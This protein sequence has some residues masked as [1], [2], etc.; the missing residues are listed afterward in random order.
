MTAADDSQL[1][2]LLR[3]HRSASGLTQEEL[4]ERAGV[5]TRAVSDIERGQRRLIYRDTARRLAS[6]LELEPAGRAEF[7]LAARGRRGGRPLD[8]PTR[9]LPVPVTPLIGRQAELAML[10]KL[11][12][13]SG[14]RV[15]TVTGPGGVGKTRLALEL[16]NAVGDA[17]ADGVCF[18]PL[19]EI[20]EARLVPRAIATAL[21]VG[22]AGE[23]L[24]AAIAAHL[25]DR[26][27]LLV[28]DNLE[29]VL[30]AVPALAEMVSFTRSVRVLATSRAP[31]KIRGE[32]QVNLDPLSPASAVALFTERALAVADV[33][34]GELAGPAVAEICARL[35]GVPL[36]IEL[37]ATRVRHL[38]PAEILSHLQRRLS[39]LGGDLVD[40]P[41][42]QRTMAATVTWSYDLLGSAERRLL[43]MLSV[44]AG[45]W[46]L[47]SAAEV[48]ADD[49]LV[50]D[51]TQTLSSLIDFS[52]VLRGPGEAGRPRYRMLDLV[53]EYAGDRLRERVQ[54]VGVHALGCRH[55]AHFTAL[56]ENAAPDLTRS[57]HLAS[58]QHLESEVDNLRT[59]LSWALGSGEVS[60]ALRLAGSLWMF[61][62]AAGAFAEGRAWLD[63]ALSLRPSRPGDERARA[64]WGAGWL[65]YQQGDFAA[66]AGRG[67][68]LLEW[69]RPAAH[70]AGVRNGVT[71]LGQARLAV[72]DHAGAAT[73]FDEALEI[74]RELDPDWMT[75]TSLLNRAV[76]DIH[77]G[78]PAHARALLAEARAIYERLGDDRFVARVMLQLTY[79][80]LLQGD[81]SAA[82]G[83]AVAA[84]KRVAALGD[85]WAVA[86]QLDAVTA[87]L[88]ASGDWER[89]AR[90]AGAAAAVWEG[91]GA[92][93]HPADRASTERWLVPAL[94]HAGAGGAEAAIAEGRAMAMSTAVK[95]A[96]EACDGLPGSPRRQ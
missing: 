32:R 34:A 21:R 28:L 77:G 91:I 5:S 62:R 46:S 85:R 26:H 76:A 35:E 30:D 83:L 48:C 47:E 7:E 39:S 61:W 86:E 71:L 37:A 84:L 25:R 51:L 42:R 82:R 17:F 52:L 10:G 73:L 36:A 4:A 15:I 9:L 74:A 12:V 96:L 22:D 50:G 23:P 40:L 53:R 93:P 3:R 87:V 59:A 72:G 49:P 69:A 64:L 57:G 56:A 43:Q 14:T 31:L 45:G 63:E 41:H 54:Q 81:P 88:A 13:D 75:A 2:A 44:F 92:R 94:E 16:C 6:A 11:L 90:L 55:A 78:Q 95:Y 1:A 19:G 70:R 65:A 29:H 67:S 20:G 18:V 79:I 33:P 89:A 68:E 60:M 24:A 8:P 38:A 27:L 58:V 80:A 66:A